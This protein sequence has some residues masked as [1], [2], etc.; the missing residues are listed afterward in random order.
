[1]SY[2][3]SKAG[4]NCR[5]PVKTKDDC[6]NSTESLHCAIYVL[7]KGDGNQFSRGCVLDNVT[8]GKSY[9][10]WNEK[11]GVKSFDPKLRTICQ[12]S[13]HEL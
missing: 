7:P 8:P 11:G 4:E 5:Q 12:S 1:M 10:Y 2:S 9:V 6:M 13:S 3:L